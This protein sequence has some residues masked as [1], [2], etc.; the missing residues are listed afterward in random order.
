ML[1]SL[2]GSEMCIRDRYT[3][4]KVRISLYRPFT[5]SNLFS[6][7]VLNNRVYLFPSISPTPNTEVENR[8]ICVAGVGNRK[9][10]GCLATNKI[11]ALDLAFEKS[12][13]FPFYTYDEDGTNRQE[14]ITDWALT[15]FRNRYNDDT[16]SKWDIFHYTYGLLHHPD[17]VSYTHLTLPTICSV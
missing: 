10:F 8:I 3:D 7:R 4:N 1:R 11:P 14:N 9:G 15:E 17:S 13:C 5:K 16:I 6:D 2:V 12:Q